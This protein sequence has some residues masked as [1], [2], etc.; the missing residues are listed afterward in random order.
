MKLKTI[1]LFLIF[2]SGLFGLTKCVTE[3]Y[4]LSG[5][6]ERYGDQSR[7]SILQF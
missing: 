2:L 1:L 4:N 5:D 3:S 6:W 7:G